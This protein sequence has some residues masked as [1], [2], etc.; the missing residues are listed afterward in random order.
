MRL[1]EVVGN[2][3]GVPGRISWEYSVFYLWWW[4]QADICTSMKQYPAYIS[5]LISILISIHTDTYTHQHRHT[6]T[7][8]PT[9]INAQRYPY[10]HT[11]TQTHTHTHTHTHTPLYPYTHL[12]FLPLLHFGSVLV[13]R[14]YHRYM[15]YDHVIKGS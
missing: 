1:G 10:L 6:H 11:H 2:S 8:T 4:V 7:Y 14:F 3:E 5:I 15:K 13:F 12:A 9:D